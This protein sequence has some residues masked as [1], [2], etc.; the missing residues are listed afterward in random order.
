M[1]TRKVHCAVLADDTN[2]LFDNKCPSEKTCVVNNKLKLLTDLLR[3]NK[4]PLNE[5]KTKLL[6]FRPLRKLNIT[7]PKIKL[8][9]FVLAPEKTVTYFGIE[10]KTFPGTNK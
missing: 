5:S 3:A 8:N 4:L 1:M 9:S 10:M 2:L 6:I 7:V